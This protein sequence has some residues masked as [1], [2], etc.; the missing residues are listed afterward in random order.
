MIS[1]V[2]RLYALDSTTLNP[3]AI[4]DLLTRTSS[5]QLRVSGLS[6]YVPSSTPPLTAVNAFQFLF[7]SGNI[8]SGTIR[9]YGLTH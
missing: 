7:S 1:G 5:N 6:I 2:L 9:V 8:A 3:N 4:F